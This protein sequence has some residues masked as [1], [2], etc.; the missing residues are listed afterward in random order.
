MQTNYGKQFTEMIYNGSSE[1]KTSSKFNSVKKMMESLKRD[2]NTLVFIYVGR[3]AKIK[4]TLLL[5]ETFNRLLDNN[6]NVCLCIVG[7]DGTPNKTYLYK[8]EQENRYPEYI[9]FVG[10]KENIGDYLSFADASCM[11]SIKE[12]LG[13]SAL[14]A[15]SIGVP[16]L[17]TPSGGPPEI[18]ISGFNGY[19][20]EETNVSSYIKIIKKFIEK[21]LLNELNIIKL[22]NDNYTMKICAMHY[23]DL[24]KKVLSIKDEL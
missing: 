3:I 4:N 20:S 7:Y 15:F 24:Y 11:T 12:G 19:V 16:M 23:I 10:R 14:E 22:Y 18:I 1:L 17:S 9:K 6:E 13:I 21:P 8:C 5:I 2:D